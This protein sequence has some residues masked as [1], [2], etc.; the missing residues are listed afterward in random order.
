MKII[1]HKLYIFFG[2]LLA[3]EYFTDFVKC[4]N[5]RFYL[6]V[7][8]VVLVRNLRMLTKPDPEFMSNDQ[9]ITITLTIQTRTECASHPYPVGGTLL[10]SRD[11]L[12][13]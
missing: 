4:D 5:V 6:I 11:S 7:S 2:N 10:S 3:S 8:G 9:I 13:S 1:I 12:E